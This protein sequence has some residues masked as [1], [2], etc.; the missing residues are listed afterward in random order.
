MIIQA[1]QLK[2]GDT[3][4]TLVTGRTGAVLSMEV[5][6]IEGVIYK[7]PV[8]V[9]VPGD[10]MT[11]TLHPDVKVNKQEIAIAIPN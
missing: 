4:K 9:L 10:G 3:F 11:K 5:F 1:W 6:E 8:V 7:G 2:P